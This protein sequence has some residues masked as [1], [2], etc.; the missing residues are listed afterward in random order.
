MLLRV[1]IEPVARRGRAAHEEF[2]RLG[3]HQRRQRKRFLALDAQHLARGDQDARLTGPLEPASDRLLGMAR[4]LLEIIEDHEAVPAPCNGMAELGHRVFVAQRHVEALG[5]GMHH[6]AQGAH[7]GQV[8]EPDTTRVVAQPEP[9]EP[10][11]QAR[12]AAAAHA[13]HRDET[14]AAF[15]TFGKSAQRVVAAD[16]GIA[17]GRQ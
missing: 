10:S 12:L 4:H 8:A 5:D 7:R 2:D 13:Q 16:E 6:P 14:G 9:A 3:R 17:L 15:E 1:G 11:G